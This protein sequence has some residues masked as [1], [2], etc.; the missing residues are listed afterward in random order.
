M[1]AGHLS[2][3][4][5]PIRWAVGDTKGRGVRKCLLKGWEKRPAKGVGKG[6]LKGSSSRTFAHA[7]ALDKKKLVR[8]RLQTGRRDGCRLY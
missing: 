5:S 3:S 6:L 1:S 4:H 8:S 7:G 2:F